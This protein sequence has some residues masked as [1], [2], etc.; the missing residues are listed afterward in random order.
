MY[1][2][3]ISVLVFIKVGACKSVTGGVDS[4]HRY[5]SRR[6]AVVSTR[7]TLAVSTVSVDRSGSVVQSSLHCLQ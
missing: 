6:Q 3:I 5:R 4:C 7:P 2:G 1:M